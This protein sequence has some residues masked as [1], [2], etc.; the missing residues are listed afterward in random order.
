MCDA[1]FLADQDEHIVGCSSSQLFV[2]PSFVIFRPVSVENSRFAAGALWS[3]CSIL[4]GCTTFRE[5]LMIVRHI[6]DIL[7]QNVHR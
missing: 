7:P 6:M 1:C 5:E 4:L 3:N 2:E